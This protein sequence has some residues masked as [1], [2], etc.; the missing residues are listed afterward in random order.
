MK[1]TGVTGWV[2]VGLLC[3]LLWGAAYLCL[4]TM[5]DVVVYQLGWPNHS[6]TM[7]SQVLL[8]GLSN[9]VTPWI[10][11]IGTLAVCGVAIGREMT[12]TSLSK[13]FLLAVVVAL[14]LMLVLFSVGILLCNFPARPVEL[15]LG[16][17]P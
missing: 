17:H 12:G 2:F 8:A 3:S 5:A 6:L 10:L 16:G 15:D 4:K 14:V 11:I 13:T 9:E 1:R 7:F